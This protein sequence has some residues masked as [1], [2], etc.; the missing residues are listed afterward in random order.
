VTDAAAVG[1]LAIAGVSLSV[2]VWAALSARGSR[3]AAEKSAAAAEESNRLT[4]EGLELQRRQLEMQRA[5][6]SRLTGARV[7]AEGWEPSARAEMRGLILHNQGPGIALEVH[8]EIKQGSSFRRGRIS[9]MAPGQKS[10]LLEQLEDFQP[11][12]HLLK[13]LPGG[14]VVARALWKNEDGSESGSDWLVLVR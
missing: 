1:G 9:S 3:K 6:R 14:S 13:N 2:A 10:S 11:T 12:E 5:E 7:V 4:S 8:G